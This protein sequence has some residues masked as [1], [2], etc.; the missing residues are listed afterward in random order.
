MV[1]DAMTA[2]DDEKNMKTIYKAAQVIR[3]S[4][5]TFDGNGNQQLSK[6]EDSPG[7]WHG[8]CAEADQETSNCSD[9]EGLE[10][11]FQ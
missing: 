11:L 4:I 5:A 7:G 9:S 2:D 10:R 3:K 6:S 1:H 8:T